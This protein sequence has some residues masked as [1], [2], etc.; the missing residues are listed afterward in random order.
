MMITVNYMFQFNAFMNYISDFKISPACC[1]LWL[2]LLYLFSKRSTGDQWYEGFLEIS[3]KKILT[4]WQQSVDSL[5]T[6]RKKLQQLGLID[7]IPGIHNKRNAQY[8][9]IYFTK[10]TDNPSGNVSDNASG[11]PSGNDAAL[12]NNLNDYSNPTMV[13]KNNNIIIDDARAMEHAIQDIW[14][15]KIGRNPTSQF[16]KN[17][18]ELQTAKWRYPLDVIGF[19]IQLASMYGMESPG[20]YVITVLADWH[21][22][23][24]RTY[25]DAKHYY[26]NY[27]SSG[28]FAPDNSGSD[29]VIAESDEQIDDETKNSIIHQRILNNLQGHSNKQFK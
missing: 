27:R 7:F 13:Y 28:G 26:D 16:L 22:H 12:N 1:Y 21:S 17:L 19:A 5:L 20:S 11:N 25:D 15:Q 8:K 3:D 2:V 6:N 23:G 14:Q 24:I 10:K 18:A 4:Y 9:L 29:H